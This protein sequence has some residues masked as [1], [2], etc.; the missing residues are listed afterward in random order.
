MNFQPQQQPQ[1]TMSGRTL[2]N[3]SIPSFQTLEPLNWHLKT[4]QD[5]KDPQSLEF[6][7]KREVWYQ[8]TW[9]RLPNQHYLRQ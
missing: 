2:V 4:L 9:K 1:M 5:V 8:E 7:Q 3:S 6:V